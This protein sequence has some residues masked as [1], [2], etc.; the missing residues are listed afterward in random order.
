MEGVVEVGVVVEE[1]GEGEEVV[2]VEEEGEVVE[3]GAGVVEEEEE[4]EVLEVSAV[5]WGDTFQILLQGT[6]ASCSS[7]SSQGSRSVR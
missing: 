2:V 7:T 5:A 3:V 4:V 6:R 1:E